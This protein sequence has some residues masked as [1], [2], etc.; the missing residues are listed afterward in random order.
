[1]LMLRL[2]TYLRKCS[3]LLEQIRTPEFDAAHPSLQAA[4][5]HYALVVIHPFADGNGRVARAIAATFL[6][7]TCDVPLV[8]RSYQDDEYLDALSAADQGNFQAFVDFIF[9][10][11]VQATQLI[12]SHLMPSLE[13]R[14]Q[15]LRGT[16]EL[17]SELSQQELRS[18][19]SELLGS[20][21][22]RVRSILDKV[23]LPKGVDTSFMWL[24]HTP[25]S[26]VDIEGYREVDYEPSSTSGKKNMLD[27]DL[28]TMILARTHTITVSLRLLGNIGAPIYPL[29]IQS[30]ETPRRVSN[31]S[32]RRAS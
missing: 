12:A 26:D 2:M 14:A 32:G 23:V 16:L 13:E 24:D 25:M 21:E 19:G 11:T 17:L 1:M 5:A 4:Y 3:V 6:I 7:K 22:M 18:I 28:T 9:D 15:L 30:V 10:C 31:T 29:L 20:L 27:I 8:I